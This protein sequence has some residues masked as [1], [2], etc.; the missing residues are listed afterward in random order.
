MCIKFIFEAKYITKQ[1][2]LIHLQ[3]YRHLC[4]SHLNSIGLIILLWLFSCIFSFGYLYS[5]LWMLDD[6][7]RRMCNTPFSF[8]SNILM[9]VPQKIALRRICYNLKRSNTTQTSI[10]VPIKKIRILLTVQ[11]V[12]IF[13][14]IL[15]ISLSIQ[16]PFSVSQF[17]W[18]AL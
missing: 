15:E 9:N 10:T 13:I 12:A 7:Y 14:F 18:I 3:R 8:N 2:V 5:H 1:I 11:M 16:F 17:H 4:R 6:S